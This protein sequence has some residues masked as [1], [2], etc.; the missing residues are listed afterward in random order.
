[1]SWTPIRHGGHFSWEELASPDGACYPEDY[2]DDDTRLAPLLDAAE[3]VRSEVAIAVGFAVPCVGAH[4]YRSP[5]YQQKMIALDEA[6][7]AA[8]L[9]PIYKAAKKSQHV[10]GRAVDYPQ[11]RELT[12]DQFQMCVKRSCS[13]P[14]IKVRYIEWRPRYRYVHLDVRPTAALKEETIN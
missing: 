12:W 9:E 11:P 14:G 10:E 2:R 4:F 6:R 1:M 7:I 3:A 13:R 5:A 8:G